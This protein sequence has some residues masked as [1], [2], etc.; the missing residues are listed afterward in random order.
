MI[1]NTVKFES[2]S[3][4]NGSVAPAP[5]PVAMKYLNPISGR[6]AN[7]EQALRAVGTRQCDSE[8]D[9]NWALAGLGRL[10]F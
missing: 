9:F 5:N 3:P 2:E 1:A 4:K 8:S 7:H 6:I 10:V